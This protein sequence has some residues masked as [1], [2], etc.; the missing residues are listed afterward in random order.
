MWQPMTVLVGRPRLPRQWSRCKPQTLRRGARLRARSIAQG[1][2][3]SGEPG[4]LG[5]TTSSLMEERRGCAP[6]PI[7]RAFL[8]IAGENFALGADPVLMLIAGDTTAL[9]KQFVGTA[10]NLIF[11]IDRDHVLLGLE[12]KFSIGSHP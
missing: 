4:A 6:G 8:A 10:A 7:L 11:Q 2:R 9:L 3:Q 1:H 12:S 5:N